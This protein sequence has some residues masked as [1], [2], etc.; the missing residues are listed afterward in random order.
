MKR[1]QECPE[2][3]MKAGGSCGITHGHVQKGFLPLAFPNYSPS[4][5]F[6][7]LILEIVAFWKL[8]IYQQ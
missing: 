8:S 2:P 4:V 1:C 7:S 3:I 6:V 5:L